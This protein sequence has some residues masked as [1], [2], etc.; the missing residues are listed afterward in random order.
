MKPYNMNPHEVLRAP[1]YKPKPDCSDGA[2]AFRL[3]KSELAVAPESGL[4]V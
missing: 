1:F 3:Q 2:P 4:A